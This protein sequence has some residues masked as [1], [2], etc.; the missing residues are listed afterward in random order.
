MLKNII[1]LIFVFISCNNINQK[2]T[3]KDFI[4]QV[5]VD[6]SVYS[7]DSFAIMS[8]L[9]LKMKNHEAS[10]QNSEYFDSTVLSI[11]TIMY[12]SSLNKIAVFAVAKNPTYR[13]PHSD[14]KLP[15]YFNANC[16]LGKR[17]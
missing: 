9:Y 4:N 1:I 17:I 11:D 13:N 15:Y 5:T 12:D 3:P 2:A 14:S 6:A 7:R 8:D 16:Y 10:Y